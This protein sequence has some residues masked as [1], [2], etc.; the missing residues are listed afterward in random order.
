MGAPFGQKLLNTYLVQCGQVCH[1]GGG[2]SHV[3]VTTQDVSSAN[4]DT[5]LSKP[6]DKNF[7][8]PLTQK[9]KF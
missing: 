4:L 5:T 2:T 3:F 6:S 8:D 9:K 7:G 1:R